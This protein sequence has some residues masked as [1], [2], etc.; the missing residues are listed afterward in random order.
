[1]DIRDALCFALSGVE[2]QDAHWYQK[3]PGGARRSVSMELR[4]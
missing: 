2:A 1:M 4:V 3:T